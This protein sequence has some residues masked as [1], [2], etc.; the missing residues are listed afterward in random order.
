MPAWSDASFAGALAAAGDFLSD[1]MDRRVLSE[2]SCLGERGRPQDGGRHD[3]EL[4]QAQGLSAGCKV[5]G[6]AIEARPGPG[7]NALFL[8]EGAR[9]PCRRSRS[10]HPPQRQIDARAPRQN[11]DGRDG[12]RVGRIC[13]RRA[14]TAAPPR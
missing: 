7:S 14:R 11:S 9:A 1:K 4:S 5:L 2:G 8:P 3:R 12:A 6:E 13:P 10:R